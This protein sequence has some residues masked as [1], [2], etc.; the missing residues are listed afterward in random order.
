MQMSREISRRS[1]NYL[2]AAGAALGT[3]PWSENLLEPTAL[4]AGNV[5]GKVIFPFGTHVYREPHL[6][7]EQFRHDFPILKR[8][9]FTMVK[10]QEVWAYD[11]RR[12]GEIDLSNVTQVVSDARQN[13]LRVYFGVTMENAP[14]WLWKKWPDATMVYET[15]QPHNDPVQYVVPADGKPGPCWHHPGARQAAVRFIE[16]VG[17]EVGKFDNVEA[18][19]VWQETGYWPMRPGYPLGVCYCAYTLSEFRRWLRSRYKSLKGLNEA[20]KCGYGDWEEVQ[21]PRFHP[22]VPPIIDFRYFM[23]DVHLSN[24]LKWKGDAFRRSDPL[25]RPI[26]A[27]VAGPTLGGAREWQFAKELDVLGSSCYPGWTALEKWDADSPA[28]G[29]PISQYVGTSHELWEGV[30]MKFDYIRSATPHGE[31]WTAE[32]QSGP[33]IEGLNRH[34]RIPDRAD[35]RRWVLGCLAG[36]VRGICFWNH[37]PEIFWQEGYGFGLLDWG[38]DSSPRAEEAGRLS[39][40]INENI[41]LFTHGQH[42][43]PEVGLVMNEDLLN[44]TEADPSS[45]RKH[46]VYT[47]RGIYKSLWTEGFSVRFIEAGAIPSTPEKTKFLILPFPVALSGRV[48]TALKNYVRNGGTV[49]AEACPGRFTNY[50]MGAKRGYMAPG[51]QDLFGVRQKRVAMIREPENGAKWVGTA[52][53]WGDTVEFHHLVGRGECAQLRVFPAYYL[54]TFAPSTATPVLTYDDDYAGCVNT[55]GK[56]RACLIGTLLGHGEIAYNDPHNRQF[57]AAL[58]TQAGIKPDQVGK[59]NRRRRVYQNKTAWFLIN[60]TDSAVEETIPITG[61]KTVH[62]LLGEPLPGTSEGVQVTVEPVGIRCLIFE[63]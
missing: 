20:W 5:E 11:E 51:A 23:N 26:L 15:G 16:G 6:P 13:G 50:G 14:A 38:S 41:E 27:H 39:K 40:A 63:S 47:I 24:V 58:L 62:D 37:R 34:Q 54:Q 4:V 32:L 57:L 10:I 36:G 52:T 25:H 43:D 2:L 22:Q 21:P 44:F 45:A 42:P 3:V 9:G 12:E 33:I 18:W 61:H 49:L 8:L 60:P 53:S 17:R 19:N 31:C 46:Y 55:Y 48:I 35:I 56:G 28:P 30:L 59:L 7:L 1:F 29:K